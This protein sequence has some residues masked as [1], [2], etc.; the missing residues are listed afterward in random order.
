VVKQGDQLALIDPPLINS[1]WN[2]QGQ[3]ARDA[4][5]LKDA[6]INLARYQ[7]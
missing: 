2:R 1:R 7:S 6:Q 3:L 4:A 5:L